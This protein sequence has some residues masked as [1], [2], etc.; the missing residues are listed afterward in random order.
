MHYSVK[1]SILLANILSMVIKLLIDLFMFAV[2]SHSHVIYTMFV[3]T[4]NANFHYK[5][6][7]NIPLGQKKNM[8]VSGFST[9]PSS[10]IRNVRP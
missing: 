6:L 8:C 10:G 5:L 2:L 3:T 1:Y 4:N 7:V 9:L